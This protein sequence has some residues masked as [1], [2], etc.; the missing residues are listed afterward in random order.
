MS[1]HHVQLHRCV[2][3][4]Q[5]SCP[6]CCLHSPL[7]ACQVHKADLAACHSLALQVDTLDDTADDEVAA[8]AFMVHVGAAYVALGQALWVDD[9]TASRKGAASGNAS[10]TE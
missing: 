5:N 1:L 4:G 6:R 10:K 2:R 8:A 7:A 9:K 3:D